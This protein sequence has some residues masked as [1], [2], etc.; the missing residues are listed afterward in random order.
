MVNRKNDASKKQSAADNTRPG[1]DTPVEAGT[2]PAPRLGST[3]GF[4][5]RSVLAVVLMTCVA[6]GARWAASRS[7]PSTVR[8]PEASKLAAFPQEIGPWRGVD[9]K[10]DPAVVRTLGTDMTLDRLYLSSAGGSIALHVAVFTQPEFKLP[11]PPELCYGGTG[12][13][14]VRTE[15]QSL[16]LAGGEQGSVRILN[17]EREDGS[18]RVTVLYCYQLGGSFAAD[19]DTVRTFFWK[20]RGQSSRPALLKVMLHCPAAGTMVEDRSL[21]FAKEVLSRLAVM[22]EDW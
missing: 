22:A 7:I 16:T 12:W 20:Y 5:F 3:R 15:D 21:D 14:V 18:N 4:L 9:Q 1:R 13:R 6:L 2:Q 11:H 8:I 19:R 17:L 10:L